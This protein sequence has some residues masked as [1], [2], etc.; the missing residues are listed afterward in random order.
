MA[1]AL[2]A[3]SDSP[4]DM[5]IMSVCPPSSVSMNSGHFPSAAQRRRKACSDSPSR[6]IAADGPSLYSN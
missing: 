6:Y 1:L 3:I 5:S 4:V 2:A